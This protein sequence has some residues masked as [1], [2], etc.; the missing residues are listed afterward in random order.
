MSRK[1][2]ILVDMDDTIENLLVEW[3]KWLNEKY[4]TNVKERDV[5]AWDLTLA[6]PGLTEEQVYEPL[7]HPELWERVRPKPHAASTLMRLMQDGHDVYITTSSNYCTLRTKMDAVLFRYFPFIQWDH[8][9]VASKKQMIRGDIMIDDGP[10]NL[11]GGDYIKVLFT[12]A[13]NRSFNEKPHDMI[14]VG[15]WEQAY[16][17]IAFLSDYDITEVRR[18]SKT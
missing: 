1:Y 7:Y 4:G 18:E 12:A 3:I 15:S 14:R 16:R 17:L 9:I 6:F 2:T 10:H 5:R 11:I 8:V 13:H